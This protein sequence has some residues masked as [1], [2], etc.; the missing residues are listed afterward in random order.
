MPQPL[1]RDEHAAI[2][3]YVATIRKS[4]QEVSELFS[5]RYGEDSSVCE[6]A[7]RTLFC[8]TLLEHELTLLGDENQD[9][10]KND[11]L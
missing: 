9:H 7:L 5:H 1:S 11:P 6:I 8:A 2:S 10:F 3:R 4:L